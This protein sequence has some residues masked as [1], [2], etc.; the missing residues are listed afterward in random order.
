MLGGWL[1]HGR[2]GGRGVLPGQGAIILLKL[3]L[4]FSFWGNAIII[5]PFLVLITKLQ[6]RMKSQMH[7][8]NNFY[9]VQAI[10]RTD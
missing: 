4:K 1:R 10:V 6:Y 2:E 8:E 5:V 3:T 9:V 7:G